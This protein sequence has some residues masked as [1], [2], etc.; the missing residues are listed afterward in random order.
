MQGKRWGKQ[1]RICHRGAVRSL[2][3]SC[4]QAEWSFFIGPWGQQWWPAHVWNRWEYVNPAH[5]PVFTLSII[6][7]EN[8]LT[9]LL[10]KFE[11]RTKTAAWKVLNACNRR[12][13]WLPWNLM[14]QCFHNNFDLEF[15]Q[16]NRS[17]KRQRKSCETRL[18]EI[19]V[20]S[21]PWLDSMTKKQ[22]NKLFWW[23]AGGRVS[24]QPTIWCK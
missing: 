6:A 1:T 20:R 8:V 17:R 3:N 18:Q 4:S 7:H 10:S 24:K 22:Q 14:S 11:N 16:G 12:S 21:L 13:D 19:I 2:S 9:W 15:D 5:Y 23:I